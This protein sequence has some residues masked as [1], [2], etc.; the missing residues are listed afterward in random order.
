MGRK[1]RY[2]SS[3]NTK[4]EREKHYKVDN[5]GNIAEITGTVDTT[6]ILSLLAQNQPKTYC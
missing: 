4:I 2:N 5:T 1:F 6:Q 3:T